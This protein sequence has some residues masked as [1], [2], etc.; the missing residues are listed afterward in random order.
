M[1]PQELANLSLAFA[2]QA[3]ADGMPGTAAAL[4]TIAEEAWLEAS[5]LRALEKR[6]HVAC[7]SEHSK[8]ER[9]TLR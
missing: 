8:A 6:T 9:V 5:A 7:T 2:M 1:H 4:R 3:E